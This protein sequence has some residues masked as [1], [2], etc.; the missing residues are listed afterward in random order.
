MSRNGQ[1]MDSEREAFFRRI[2]HSLQL[3][4]CPADV[5]IRSFPDFV[6]AEDRH[7][8][9]IIGDPAWLQTSAQS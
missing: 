2:K 9:L 6:H 1:F 4:A 5:Q 7:P 8:T 3:L